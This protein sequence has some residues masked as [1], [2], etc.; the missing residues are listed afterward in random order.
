MSFKEK[1]GPWAVVTGASDGIGRAIAIEL[2]KRGLNLIL[3][4][5][6]KEQL[7]QLSL[8]VRN[9]CNLEIVILPMDLSTIESA[10]E[11]FD[12]SRKYDVGLLAAI[13]GFGTSGPLIDADIET[14]LSMIDLNCRSVVAQCFYFGKLFA[15][16]KRGGLVLMSS[17][18]AFQGVPNAANYSATKSFIQNFAEGLYFELKPY[19]VSVLASA[20]GP[21]TTGFARRA[22]MMMSNAA[23]PEEVAQATLR[24]LGQSITVRPGFLSKLLGWSLLTMPR[25]ERVFVMKKIMGQMTRHQNTPQNVER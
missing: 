11:L 12:F 22:N 5:R 20:P 6:R 19:Q 2:A 25:R 10:R 16:K 7:E 15:E 21:V 8:E 9:F 24:A 14:E 17:L 4:A 18:L 3:V 1:Y 13:A 23:R